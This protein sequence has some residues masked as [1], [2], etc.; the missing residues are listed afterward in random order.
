MNDELRVLIK[1]ARVPL[2]LVHPELLLANRHARVADVD[3]HRRSHE[4][5]ERE[6]VDRDAVVEEVLRRV[7]V[8]ARVRAERQRRDVRAGALRERLLR[9]DRD[10][11]IP[12]INQ[13][14][15][16]DRE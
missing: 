5:V 7:D 11:G 13:P 15:A 10:L 8:R 1:H 4:H 3:E 14:A 2:E 12:G 6:R 9:S 16:D